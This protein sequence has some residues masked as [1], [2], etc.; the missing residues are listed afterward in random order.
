MELT[1]PQNLHDLIGDFFRMLL[2]SQSPAVSAGDASNGTRTSVSRASLSRARVTQIMQAS[3]SRVGAGQVELDGDDLMA[4]HLE[5]LLL[6]LDYNGVL[7]QWTEG[8]EERNVLP[9]RELH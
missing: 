2:E 5:M 7:T 4:R 6:R 1:F 9:P 3:R 8:R